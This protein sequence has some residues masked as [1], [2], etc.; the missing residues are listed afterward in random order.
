M[1]INK[2]IE[3]ARIAH[4]GQ[5][6]KGG[7]HYIDH[8]LRVMAN[9]RTAEEKIV[10]ALHDAVE[11]SSLTLEDLRVAGFSDLIVDAIDAISKREGEKRN[12]YLRRVMSNTIA[13]KVK[14]ADIADNAN[15]LRIEHPTDRDIERTRIYKRT[16]LKL[17]KKLKN[18]SDASTN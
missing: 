8:P 6:D 1:N 2:A 12:D 15:L 3:L 7:Q 9:V 5:V 14:I 4:E 10:A 16:I 17:Q 18:I 13:L 11:D